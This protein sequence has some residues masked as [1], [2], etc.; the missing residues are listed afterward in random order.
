ME[1]GVRTA[2]IIPLAPSTHCQQRL[3]SWVLLTPPHAST[4]PPTQAATR[5]RLRNTNIAI[6][7]TPVPSLILLLLLLLRLL[8][9]FLLQLFFLLLV[10]LHI[11]FLFL[12]L[13][14]SPGSWQWRHLD[15]LTLAS[16]TVQLHVSQQFLRMKLCNYKWTSPHTP[17]SSTLKPPM[18]MATGLTQPSLSSVQPPA[19]CQ[20]V[21]PAALPHLTCVHL[22]SSL[23]SGTQPCWHWRR[24]REPGTSTSLLHNT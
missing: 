2:L 10:L 21:L 13:T 1:E 11:L 12:L 9:L 3:S 8:L 24:H 7:H 14:S 4:L 16:R 5:P 23:L 17:T 22:V 6:A 19:W 18:S 20:K 15:S